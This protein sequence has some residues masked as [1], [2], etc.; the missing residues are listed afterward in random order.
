MAA[1]LVRSMR[2]DDAARIGEIYNYYVTHSHVTFEEDLV[3]PDEM[4]SR[5]E[6]ICAVF[7][8]FV[9]EEAGRVAGY[10][11][12]N[13]WR[14]RSSYRYSVEVSAYVDPDERGRGIGRMVY[15][16]VLDGLHSRGVHAVLA[17]I[18]QPNVASERLHERLGFAKVAHLRE[19]GYKF[20]RWIDVA[21]WQLV[22]APGTQRK[23][24]HDNRT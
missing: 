18:A 4:G 15:R 21:Y 24:E 7:P 12:A 17:G 22:F 5:V 2:R 8:A 16:S 20:D 23:D 14:E 13:K 6:A 1:G 10:A 9:W 11:W 19:V 3:G